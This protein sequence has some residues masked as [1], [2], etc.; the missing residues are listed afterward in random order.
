MEVTKALTYVKMWLAQR[1][2]FL[3]CFVENNFHIRHHD[4][5]LH[6]YQLPVWK[7]KYEDSEASLILFHWRND[8]SVMRQGIYPKPFLY[9]PANSRKSI[10]L[11][12]VLTWSLALC[13]S[14]TYKWMQCTSVLVFLKIGLPNNLVY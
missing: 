9:L 11:I 1:L 12:L 5:E 7:L 3:K 2:A 10:K 8:S 13:V 14:S 6:Y 4:K